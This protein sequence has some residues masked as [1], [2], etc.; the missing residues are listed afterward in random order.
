[1]SQDH[2]QACMRRGMTS[3]E[4]FAWPPL[5]SAGTT[6]SGTSRR[7]HWPPASAAALASAPQCIIH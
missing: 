7:C 3:E 4:G 1:M 5:P 6:I 2:G